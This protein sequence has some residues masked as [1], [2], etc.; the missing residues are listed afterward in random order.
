[1]RPLFIYAVS[2]SQS[3]LCKTRVFDYGNNQKIA[4]PKGTQDGYSGSGQPLRSCGGLDDL[5]ALELPEVEQ[6]GI[7]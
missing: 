6:V 2:G 4:A 3:A 7:T 5:N 1:M